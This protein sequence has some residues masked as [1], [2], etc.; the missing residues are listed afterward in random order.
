MGDE[1]DEVLDREGEAE[2]VELD[3]AE[4]DAQAAEQA[5]GAD[6]D[7]EDG[8]DGEGDT[9]DEV[10]ITIGDASPTPEDEDDSRAPVWVGELRKSH[11]EQARRIREL[12]QQVT[13][14]VPAQQAVVVGEKPKFEDCGYDTEKFERELEAWHTRKQAAEAEVAKKQSAA[15]SEKK[16]WSARLE[17]HGKLKGELKVKDYDEAEAAV[18]VALSVTQR[19]LIVHGADNSAQ[20]TY[21]L[22]KNP[23][24]L[25]DLASITDP[26]KFAFAVAK[27]ETKLKVTPRKHAPTPER[28]VR[29]NASPSGVVDNQLERLRAE[30]VKSGD[31]SKVIAYKKAQRAKQRA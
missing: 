29:G 24:T 2:Q 13:A 11:R 20:L 25:K 30:A 8:E 4:Q 17:H 31:L 14:A 21:A 9:T 3:D 15:E 12:E 19:G 16:A 23:K 27:L 26:V 18:E 22:G 6:G 5:E 10:T 28:N 7:A 1:V